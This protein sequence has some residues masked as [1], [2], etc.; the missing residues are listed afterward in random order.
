MLNEI[1]I[2]CHDYLPPNTILVSPDLYKLI[3]ESL[4]FD[5]NFLKALEIKEEKENKE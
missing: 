4:D 1:K 2:Q 3:K 5:K